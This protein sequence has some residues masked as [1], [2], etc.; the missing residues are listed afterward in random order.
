MRQKFIELLAKIVS[1]LNWPDVPVSAEVPKQRG[2]GDISTN[3][4]FLLAKP[5]KK[6]PREVAAIL[7]EKL[8]PL[9]EWI[10]KIDVAGAGFINCHIH[11]KAYF[12]ALQAVYQSGKKFGVAK[13]GQGR[14]IL[15]EFVSANPT[16]PLNVVSARAAAV[17]DTLA[18]LLQKVGY[19]A[20]KEFYVNDVGVQIDL[21]GQSLW[22]RYQQAVGKEA[23]LPEE[24]YQGEY[25][26]ERAAK[27]AKQKKVIRSAEVIQKLGLDGMVAWQKKSLKNFGVVFDRWF[28][29]SEL[30]GSEQFATVLKPLQ[31][32][33]YLYE[34]EGALFFQSSAFGDDKDR[35]VK[36]QD[37]EYTYFASDIVYHHNKFARG[38]D[39]CI[40]LLGPDHHGYVARTK[41]AVA[42][43]GYDPKR[44]TIL[45]VQ[46]VNLIQ[47][48]KIVKMS[49][50]AGKL[51]TMD[52]LLEEVGKD[53]ARYFFL[54]RSLNTP[55]DFDLELAK[56]QTL[57]N[58]VFYIQYAHARIASIF[59]KAAE[60]K[61]KPVFSKINC[62]DLDLPEEKELAK[63]VLDFPDVVLQAAEELEPHFIAFYVLDLARQFQ[64]YY[65]QA[66]QDPRYKV[67]D[68]ENRERTLAKLYLLK[69]IQIVL[70]N[71]LELMGISAPE[72]MVSSSS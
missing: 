18:R 30:L 12:E 21:F 64:S 65:S 6:S 44:L 27:L 45:I 41:A 63:Q 15:L 47:S 19:H 57:E 46:Q 2:H 7:L 56:Q 62:A 13:V 24:G 9:P 43:L 36:K 11:P 68:P 35:V 29:Q 72:R 67:V 5:L 61:I 49:K 31:E 8:R 16:G 51:V 20:E 22:A 32:K 3:L 60:Q 52:D 33:N 70:Q 66:K 38:F 17:G 58:P 71:A 1:D 37:S 4:A 26:C 39:R 42:A 28:H 23:A 40:D 25:L 69:N 50:R 53:V 48:E 59:K 14:K 54:Q 10:K 55:L 34:K